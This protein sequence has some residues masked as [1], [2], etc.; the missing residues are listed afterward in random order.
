MDRRGAFC[1]YAAAW[2]TY[3]IFQRIGV[4]TYLKCALVGLL[5]LSACA[6]S[7]GTLAKMPNNYFDTVAARLIMAGFQGVRMVDETTNT[8]V[9]QDEWGNEVVTVVH[10][11]NR[12]ILTQS[13]LHEADK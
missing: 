2:A 11:Q 1:T 13:F 4:V 10:P 6:A 3:A 9:A 5:V 12:Q 8:L 7:A